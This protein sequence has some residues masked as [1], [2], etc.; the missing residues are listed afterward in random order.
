MVTD[1]VQTYTYTNAPHTS[2]W[3][4]LAQATYGTC[5]LT[6][7]QLIRGFG[8]AIP[9]RIPAIAATAGT[10]GALAIWE[11]IT[12]PGR[13]PKEAVQLGMNI[14]TKIH[15]NAVKC[16]QILKIHSSPNG[17]C[18]YLLV[19]G[20][21]DNALALTRLDSNDPG[22]GVELKAETKPVSSIAGSKLKMWTLLIPRAHAAAITA[23]FVLP[24]RS[25]PTQST[26]E[27]TE[28]PVP[29]ASKH[30]KIITASNDQRLKQWKVG[31][32]LEKPGV[33]GFDLKRYA[34][35]HT[36]VADASAMDVL[37]HAEDSIAW[38]HD[39]VCTDTGEKVVVCGVGI[40]VSR[41]ND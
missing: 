16:M 23:V 4:L 12:L 10:D 40:E 15:Q 35:T 20:G 3:Q 1:I 29:R 18:S 25:F 11:M 22:A 5:C 33:E 41:V 24:D 38:E 32:D 19:T 17:S 13:P 34:N 30:F 21:D 36:A 7:I 26:L 9:N 28:E 2:T 8:D 37:L 39:A 14:R 31:I 6:Q 27:S